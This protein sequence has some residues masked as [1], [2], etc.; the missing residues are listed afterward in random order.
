MSPRR[1]TPHGCSARSTRPWCRRRRR[2]WRLPMSD[3]VAATAAALADEGRFLV[4]VGRHAGGFS[5]LTGAAAGEVRAPGPGTRLA[6]AAGILAGGH[7]PIVI[8]DAPL[9]SVTHAPPV[10][11]VTDDR[12]VAASAVRDGWTVLQP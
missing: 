1:P 9:P 11:A 8:A 7:R 2:S 4:V 3:L 5:A 10:L 12:T 6:V